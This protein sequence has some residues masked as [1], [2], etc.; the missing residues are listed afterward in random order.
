M[1]AFL[2]I[3]SFLNGK[4][5][6]FSFY[7]AQKKIRVSKDFW[8]HPHFNCDT[9]KIKWV[10]SPICM[11]FYSTKFPPGAIPGIFSSC[12]AFYKLYACFSHDQIFAIHHSSVENH[13]HF[14]FLKL[15]KISHAKGFLV[16]SPL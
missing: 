8:L 16:A 7:E 9:I 15:L 11:T 4:F 1:L 12:G 6:R 3:K 5:P 14:H 10:Y 2:I 13:K